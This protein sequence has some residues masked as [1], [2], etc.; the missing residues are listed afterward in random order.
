ML[1]N[2]LEKN[3]INKVIKLSENK[4]RKDI[5][6]LLKIMLFFILYLNLIK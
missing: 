1:S 3:A 4:E 5:I 2:Y 6:N